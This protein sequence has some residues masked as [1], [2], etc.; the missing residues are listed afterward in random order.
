MLNGNGFA[1]DQNATSSLMS[2]PNGPDGI[3]A[4]SSRNGEADPMLLDAMGGSGGAAG[5]AG[6]SGAGGVSG[7]EGGGNPFGHDSAGLFGP[8]PSN[9]G[10]DVHA[11]PGGG[12]RPKP[13]GGGALTAEEVYRNVTKPY[14]HA[15]SYHFLVKHLK[16]RCVNFF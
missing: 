16:E 2:G 7:L 3:L 9:V 5:G 1:V 15:K 6:M 10:Q 13:S 8:P 12:V 11:T 4:G 14:P